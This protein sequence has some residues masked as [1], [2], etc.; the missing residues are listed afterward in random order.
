MSRPKSF[1]LA[2]LLAILALAQAHATAS[3]ETA[4]AQDGPLDSL[5]RQVGQRSKPVDSANFVRDSRPA[6]LNYVPVHSKRPEPQGKL[7]TTEELKAK[8]HELDALHASHDKAGERR[9]VKAT[10]KPLRAP[11]PPKKTQPRPTVEPQPVKLV[12]PTLR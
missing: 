8:E 9:S 2:A 3:A 5:A 6:E 10:Y 1:A 4:A 12:I 11:A 7:L